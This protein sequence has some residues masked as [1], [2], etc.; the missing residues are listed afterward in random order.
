MDELDRQARKARLV[1]QSQPRSA[2]LVDKRPISDQEDRSK[3]RRL[4]FKQSVSV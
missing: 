3:K 2:G 4:S 1:G